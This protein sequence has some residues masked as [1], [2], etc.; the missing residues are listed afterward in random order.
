MSLCRLIRLLLVS[1][2]TN[3]FR[4]K[5]KIMPLGL[6]RLVP[7][8]FLRSYPQATLHCV[9][10]NVHIFD[11]NRNALSETKVSSFKTARKKVSSTTS[12]LSAFLP[13][14]VLSLH[15]KLRNNNVIIFC[16]VALKFTVFWQL[17][18]MPRI[19]ISTSEN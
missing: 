8:P 6:L 10:C 2:S 4:G 7:L 5:K 17:F 13:Q 12:P 9:C 1:C 19:P 16:R 15:L 11:L 3:K 18:E 14:S